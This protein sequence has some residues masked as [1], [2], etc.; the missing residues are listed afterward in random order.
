MDVKRNRTLLAQLAVVAYW[1]CI[2]LLRRGF[3]VQIISFAWYDLLL[4]C[5][6]LVGV[7]FVQ[8][9][10]S[11]EACA[12]R[13]HLINS[14]TGRMVL[15]LSMPCATRCPRCRSSMS[16][17]SATSQS[18]DSFMASLVLRPMTTRRWRSRG[19]PPRCSDVLCSD[20]GSLP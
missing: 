3:R 11:V 5:Q 17:A 12:V 2:F 7:R 8:S 14:S 19:L 4:P 13:C 15:V 9:Q 1:Q 10:F 18:T 20:Y 16:S 6:L